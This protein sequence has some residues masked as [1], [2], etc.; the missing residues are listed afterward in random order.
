MGRLLNRYPLTCAG[1]A[2]RFWS[3]VRIADAGSCW[4]WIGASDGHGYGVFNLGGLYRCRTIKAH[5]MAFSIAIGAPCGDVCHRCDNPSCANPSHLFLGA[6]ID[7]LGDMARKNRGK[8]SL[9]GMPF[10]VHL[11]KGKY[12]AEVSVAGQKYR[13]GRFTDINEAARVAAEF[14]QRQRAA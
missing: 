14:K 6:E 9:R 11:N 7:N 5:R 13:L 2:A 10:G 12:C 4:Q 3:H 1:V 8:K